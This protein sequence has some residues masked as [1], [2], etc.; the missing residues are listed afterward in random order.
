MNEKGEQCATFAA[1]EMEWKL[2]LLGMRQGGVIILLR[3]LNIHFSHM[4]A[5]G[6]A[7]DVC[8]CCCKLLFS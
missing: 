1:R 7:A 4:T 5:P 2:Q 8:V 6:E 3:F